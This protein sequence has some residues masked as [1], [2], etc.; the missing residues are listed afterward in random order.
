MQQRVPTP[1]PGVDVFKLP[2]NTL[3]GFVLSRVDG[4]ASVEDISIM[5][6]IDKDR[7]LSILTRLSELGAVQLSWLGSRPKPPGP[8][9]QATTPLDRAAEPPPAPDAHFARRTARF[10]PAEHDPSVGIPAESRRRILNAVAAIEGM[11][12]Y[13]VLGVKRDADK[14]AIRNAYFELSK[15]FHPDAYFGKELG[16]FRPKMEAVFKKLTEAYDTLGKA[17]RRAEYDEY[18]ASTEQTQRVRQTLESIELTS[19]EVEAHRAAVT[20]A[21]QPVARRAE[22]SS[23]LRAAMTPPSAPDAER[24]ARTSLRAQSTNAE[25]RARVRDRLLQRMKA[26]SSM[27]PPEPASPSDMAGAKPSD[28]VPSDQRRRSLIDGLKQSI[29]AATVVTSAPSAQLQSLM[30]K[31]REAEQAGDVLGAAGQLQVALSIEPNDPD[32]VREYDRVSKV[33]AR[34]LAANYEKQALY[35]EK[36]G[37]W[38]AAARSWGRASDG[39]PEDPESA[40]RTAEAMLKSS[41][42]LHRAQAYAQRAVTLDGKSVQNLT[43]LARVY[44]AAGL[45][46]NAIR[47]LE[48]AAQ[49]APKDEMVNNLLRE[50]R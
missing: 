48:K 31:A 6:G 2:L 18:L 29:R 47:E 7:V 40:R 14:K 36:T 42:D 28:P 10:D 37:N 1:V 44:L 32:V 49:L 8:A 34:N 17:K 27:R 41:G 20:Q 4:S 11:N 39:R 9:R 26:V 24:E 15:L 23:T 5:S 30:K 38:K 25:R 3:E 22:S 33:V 45:K 50:V 35:E 46:L 12:L 16:A 19:E 43:V 21:Q 13:Q